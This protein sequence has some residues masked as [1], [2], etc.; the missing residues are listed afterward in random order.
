[1]G[2]NTSVR[3]G[4]VVPVYYKIPDVVLIVKF[5]KSLVGDRLKKKSK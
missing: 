4:K 5:S 3:E 1:M 2:V